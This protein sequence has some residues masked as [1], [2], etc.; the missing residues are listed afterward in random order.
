MKSCYITKE[1]EGIDKEELQN[2]QEDLFSPEALLC[3]DGWRDMLL[4]PVYQK[5]VVALV[6][7]E[8]HL[9]VSSYS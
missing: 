6:I 1:S 5:N 2:L 8:A 4:T 3:N 9:M 7:D